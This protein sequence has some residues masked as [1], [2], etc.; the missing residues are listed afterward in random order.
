ML[1]YEFMR[2]AILAGLLLAIAAPSI[3]VW[4]TLKRFSQIGDSLAHTSLV[5]VAAA[6]LIGINPTVGSLLATCLFAL[7]LE[8]LQ[9]RFKR[10]AEISLSLISVVA[11]GMV[12][13][14]FT[15]R[16]TSSNLMSYLFGSIVLIEWKDV[17]ILLAVALLVISFS[18]KYKY[19][20][21]Y[22]T[23]DE[24][25]AKVSGINTK[26][27]DTLINIF[28]A[29]VIGVSI[30][31]VGG[32]I[33]SALLVFPVAIAMRLSHNFKSLQLYSLII[34]IICVMG[35]IVLSFY[36]D[37][38]SGGS[39]ILCFIAVFAFTEMLRKVLKLN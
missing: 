3:G 32:L 31:I 25:S 13:I 10:F 38:P 12:S 19:K 20:L 4:T 18:I 1:E 2:R 29:L 34:S 27:F 24:I 30:R 35:G 37:L 22:T 9:N 39:I 8:F 6:L 26:T 21:L 14:L 36:F 11:I 33:I 28:A 5:G 23:F 16:K 15:I 7:V 17:Y